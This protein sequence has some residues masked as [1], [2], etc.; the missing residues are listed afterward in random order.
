MRIKVQDGTVRHGEA[1]LCAT[2]AHSKIIRGETLS[3]RIVECHATV[4]HGRVIPFRVTS[5]TAYADARQPSYMEMV[6]TAWILMPHPTKRRSAGFVRGSDLSAREFI[7]VA[8]ERSEE[9]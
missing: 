3:E 6:R 4:M 7:A 9:V 5:C 2:C 1:S 8:A